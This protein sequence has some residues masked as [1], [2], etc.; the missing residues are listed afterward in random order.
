MM[1]EALAERR[2]EEREALTAAVA[3]AI[4]VAL[5]APA[6]DEWLARRGGPR[7]APVDAAGLTGIA[8]RFP[9]AIRDRR[10]N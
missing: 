10:A 5:S 3:E 8:A 4:A 9:A 2:A 7:R 6:R 1:V